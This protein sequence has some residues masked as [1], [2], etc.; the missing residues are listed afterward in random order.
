VLDLDETPVAMGAAIALVAFGA[1]STDAFYG[2]LGSE[3]I[4]LMIG[5]F[6]L[7][8]AIGQS[9]LAERFGKRLMFGAQTVD[10]LLVR[11]TAFIAATAFVIPSTSARAALLLPMFIALA[12]VIDRPRITRALALLFPTVILLS[13]CASLLG[14][15]AHLVAVDFMKR[16]S[17]DAPG[18]I[19]WIALA[20]PFAIASSFI[21]MKVVA[22]MFLSR[23]ERGSSIVLSNTSD[24]ADETPMS[25]AQRR[26]VYIV[27][28]TLAGWA[29]T[30]VHGIDAAIIAMIGALAATTPSLT[31][32]D[33][34]TAIKKVEWNLVLFLAATMVLGEALQHS[35]AA[36]SIAA[37]ALALVPLEH[38][39][40][41]A[42]IAL[43]AVIALSSHLLITS[44]TVRA[45][46]LIPTIA[47]PL[48][49]NGVD[50]TLMIFVAVIGSGFCQTFTVS[51]KP[52]AV[53]AQAENSGITSGTLAGLSA[54]LFLPLLALLAFFA[55]VIWP[56][57]GL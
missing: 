4:W 33:I 29:L 35:G 20:A 48:A 22:W 37:M 18:F 43:C 31:G 1:A 40:Q 53:F 36:K 28:A 46:I 34:K 25:L 10:Q 54:V 26:L 42:I 15:G 11:V 32:V 41:S 44:R 49:V 56:L 14:A 8:A 52:V 30:D 27:G 5:G 45:T 6:I 55:M 16:V 7:A 12:R 57:Q 21:A 13:A 24:G 23:D 51:A 9:G 38:F 19:G 39:S 3:L 17:G 47:L 2:A 50:A